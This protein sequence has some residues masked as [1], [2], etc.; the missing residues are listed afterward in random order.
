M[1]M[2]FTVTYLAE[3]VVRKKARSIISTNEEMYLVK[4]KG[5]VKVVTSMEEEY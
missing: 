2:F 4:K 3:R 5:W 1:S